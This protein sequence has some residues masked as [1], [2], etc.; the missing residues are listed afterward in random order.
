LEL[1]TRIGLVLK[2]REK[3]QLEKRLVR[4]KVATKSGEV[5][6]VAAIL[7]EWPEGRNEDA[8]WQEMRALF[9]HILDLHHKLNDLPK[10]TP[11]TGVDLAEP[12]VIVGSQ[13]TNGP[14]DFKDALFVRSVQVCFDRRLVLYAAVGCDRCIQRGLFGSGCILSSGGVTVD[15]LTDALVVSDGDVRVSRGHKALIIA[16]G[17]VI[18]DGPWIDCHVIAGKR[19]VVTYR[20]SVE[21]GC[22]VAENATAPLGFVK[23]FDASRAGVQIEA[24]KSGVRVKDLDASRSFAKAGLRKGDIIVAVDGEAVDSVDTFRR[25]LRHSL[26]V[27]DGLSLRVLRDG[28]TH[29]VWL[30][31]PW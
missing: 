14:D 10:L 26:V 9:T 6:L 18:C 4:L 15:Q 8:C 22:K 25:L 11:F 30:D 7:A 19:L 21:E 20:G 16:R 12:K 28:R 31:T 29:E 17:N 13:V 24:A 1:S 3:R 27:D 5:D 2:E 23:F